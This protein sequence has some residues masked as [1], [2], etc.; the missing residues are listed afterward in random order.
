MSKISHKK[1]IWY[2]KMLQDYNKLYKCKAGHKGK[3]KIL[4]PGT[5][6][7]QR[8]DRI[9]IHIWVLQ[10]VMGDAFPWTYN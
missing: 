9:T 4:K 7:H 6:W 1:E 2:T 5:N 10:T 8:L 3:V